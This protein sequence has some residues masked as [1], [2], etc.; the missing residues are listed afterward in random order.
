[1]AVGRWAGPLS[2][3]KNGKGSALAL[4]LFLFFPRVSIAEETRCR[5]VARLVYER[6]AA[7]EVCPD[8]QAVLRTFGEL[9]Q[10]RAT[11]PDSCNLRV[12]VSIR[13]PV[14]SN[15]HQLVPSNVRQ[16]GPVT[17]GQPAPGV[18]GTLVLTDGQGR[19]VWT[20]EMDVPAGECSTLIASLAL[21]LRIA[22]GL[23]ESPGGGPAHGRS[24]PEGTSPADQASSTEE[25]ASPVVIRGETLPLPPVPPPPSRSGSV[26]RAA[27]SGRHPDHHVRVGFAV[28]TGAAP[29]GAPRLSLGHVARW[30]WGS[31]GFE[32][33]GLLPVSGDFDGHRLQVAR[34]EGAIM[35]CLSEAIFFVCGLLSAG[36]FWAEVG[37]A[38]SQLRS[39]F[40]AGG[41]ARAGAELQLTSRLAVAAHLDIEGTFWPAV[42]H[43][44]NIAF[45]K[46]A[47]GQI[48]LGLSVSWTVSGS[49]W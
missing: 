36:A 18:R 28:V 29:R 1:M 40:R 46:E 22:Q 42:I 32:V 34:W 30:P 25:P 24:D 7:A 43:I 26:P 31:I 5:S 13:Q 33:R 8:E 4:G 11:G 47:A 6:S 3:R 39:A 16:L 21:S 9:I 48:A 10:R 35:P 15:V 2:G 49:R 19:S 20:N 44:T 41:G 27:D 17:V 38:R 37:G 45:W 12:I 14:P 23:D